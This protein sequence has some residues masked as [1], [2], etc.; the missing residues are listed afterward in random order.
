M[1]ALTLGQRQAYLTLLA[2]TLTRYPLDPADGM[3]LGVLRGIPHPSC[4]EIKR[5]YLANV[6]ALGR[7]A[8]TRGARHLGLDWPSDAET[9]IG[10]TRLRNV[11]RC[12]E[13]VLRRGVPGDFMETGVWRGGACIYLR[14]IL[15]A[16]ADRDRRVWVADSFQG[17]PRPDPMSY[18]ADRG[19]TLFTYRQLA[20]SLDAVKANF[21]RYG[22]LD[23]QVC[24]LPGWFRDTL[25]DAPVGPLAVLR[26]D[27]DLYESTIVALRSLYSKISPG[28][29]VI[30][31]DYGGIASCRQAVDD[32]RAELGIREPL[33]TID[34]AGVF[35][36][37][38]ERGVEA[39]GSLVSLDL[40]VDQP[41]RA[42]AFYSEVFGWRIDTL[43]GVPDYWLLGGGPN[44]QAAIRGALV[45][46]R[47]PTETTTCWIEVTSVDE[48]LARVVEH[49]GVALTTKQTLPGLAAFVYCQDTEGNVLG[50]VQRGPNEA[51]GA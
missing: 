40:G 2:K 27:G 22:Y 35:W 32:F 46:R 16:Y 26:L 12:A 19:D 9:M 17:V 28:G 36:Q 45:K 50:L 18:E 38:P 23:D 29:Y 34:W 48:V 41:E 43:P 15:A 10:L 30:V 13:E 3:L 24:F 1:N 21:F 8:V 47:Y 4:R 7:T 37:V 11:Q 31:D 20:V 42:Q 33:Q 49:G 51:A 6:W 14:A 44:G 5:W 25:P 39:T